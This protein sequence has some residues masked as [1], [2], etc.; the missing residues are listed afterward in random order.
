MGAIIKNFF[1]SFR[2]QGLIWFAIDVR[3][4]L[5]KNLTKE[6]LASAIM[7]KLHILLKLCCR[8]FILKHSHKTINVELANKCCVLNNGCRV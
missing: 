1:W 8:L 5:V 6:F 7:D 2:N 3:K 4:L